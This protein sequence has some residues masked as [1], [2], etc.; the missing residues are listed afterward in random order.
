D[1]PE[2]FTAHFAERHF[3]AALVADHAAVLHPLVLPAQAFPVRDRAKN[4]GTKQAVALRFEGAVVDGLGLGD[5]AVR[6]GTD[7]FRTRQADGNG[8]EIRNQ[9]GAII[10]AAAIQGCFLPPRLS[11]G[12]R[13]GDWPTGTAENPTTE[14][15]VPTRRVGRKNQ[16]APYTRISR[17]L[18]PAV[19]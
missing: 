6:P 3:H 19:F 13:P 11:P 7:F 10:G 5:F 2:A 16:G 9:A 15:S 8:I 14:T 4:L 17:R 12:T 18:S 1:M